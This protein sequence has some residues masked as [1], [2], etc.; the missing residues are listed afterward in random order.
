MGSF[1][2]NLQIYIMITGWPFRDVGLETS[3][4]SSSV[5]CYLYPLTQLN[6]FPHF[7][8][9]WFSSSKSPPGLRHNAL[10][11]FAHGLPSA[12]R[13]GFATA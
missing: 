7:A 13:V 4:L 10:V 11:R 1:V 3:T 9:S 12:H 6:A 5:I 2:A 8:A